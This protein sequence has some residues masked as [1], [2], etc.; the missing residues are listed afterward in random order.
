MAKEYN[1][2][3]TSGQCASCKEPMVADQ[4]FMATVR[5]TEDDF[6]REDYCIQCWDAQPRQS[7][8]DMLGVWR[9][10]VPQPEQKKK[11]FVDDELL[12][13]F[14][15]R[16]EGAEEP[17]KINFRF[18]LA[19]VLMR[20]RVLVYDRMTKGAEGNETWSMHFKGSDQVH[21]VVDPRMN[22]EQIAAVSQHLGQI[23]EGEL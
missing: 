18:V 15:Q 1:I 9:S 12:V 7:G 6:V 5:E 3:K 23:L 11:L 19:L 17:A 8:P 4:E 16:L 14:F 2:S 13:N 22:E 10:R 20:K 21:Q